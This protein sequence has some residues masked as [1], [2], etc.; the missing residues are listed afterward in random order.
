LGLDCS[1]GEEVSR[2]IGE[3]E[4]EGDDSAKVTKASR[5]NRSSRYIRNFPYEKS[6]IENKYLK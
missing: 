3:G 2:V 5:M 6:I 1:V 4:G